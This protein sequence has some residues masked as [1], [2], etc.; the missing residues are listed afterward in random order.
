MVIIIQFENCYRPTAFQSADDP[1][2]QKYNFTSFVW[3]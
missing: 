3:F 1:G 2:T